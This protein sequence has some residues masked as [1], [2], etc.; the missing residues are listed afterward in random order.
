MSSVRLKLNV[1]S[2]SEKCQALRNV[3]KGPQTKTSVKNTM[4]P[5]MK[6]S[7]VETATPLNS[8]IAELVLFLR[9]WKRYARAFEKI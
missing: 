4:Y 9:S 2:L 7:S 6:P 5:V 1:K 8:Y 3:K